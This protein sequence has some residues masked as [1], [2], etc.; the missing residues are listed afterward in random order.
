MSLER[1]LRT[2]V[3]VLIFNNISKLKKGNS[4]FLTKATDRT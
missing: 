2:I 4:Q 1:I 3:I